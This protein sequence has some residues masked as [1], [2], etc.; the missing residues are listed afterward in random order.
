LTVVR[1]E[2]YYP[3][4]FREKEQRRFRQEAIDG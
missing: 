4:K 1:A 3:A 2:A